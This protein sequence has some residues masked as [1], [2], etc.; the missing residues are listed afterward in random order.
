QNVLGSLDRDLLA[1]VDKVGG[2]F[3]PVGFYYR[4]MI[5]PRRAWPLYERF[6]RNVAGLGRIDRHAERSRRFD[7]EHRRAEVLVIGGGATGSI[8]QPLVF[9][10]NDLVGVMLPSAV[11]RLVREWAIK[12]GE[13]AAVVTVDDRGLDAA[14]ALRSAG[15][16]VTEVFDLREE[17]LRR[18]AA[19]GRR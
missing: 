9:P 5:R 11:R 19:H 12:P 1:I 14:Q 8:E 16:E 7:T 2:P 13:R 4:T 3:T 17:R 18:I 15:V 10:G 6:L